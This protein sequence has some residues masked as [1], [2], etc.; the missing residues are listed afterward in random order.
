MG[1]LLLYVIGFIMRMVYHGDP[2][3]CPDCL[4]VA[5]IILAFS[6]MVSFFRAI[7]FLSV[8]EATGPTIYMIR[9]LVSS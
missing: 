4:Y 2:T 1:T 5:R 6:L 9:H 7:Q 8:F 3:I